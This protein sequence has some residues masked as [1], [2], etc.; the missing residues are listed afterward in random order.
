VAT[1]GVSMAV[2]KVY[3]HTGDLVIIHVVDGDESRSKDGY[4]HSANTRRE[5]YLFTFNTDSVTYS[6]PQYNVG[7]QQTTGGHVMWS[8]TKI[9]IEK[10]ALMDEIAELKAAIAGTA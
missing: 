5:K 3:V 9:N 6:C 7:Y 8:T 2:K 4:D 1:I 10:Q